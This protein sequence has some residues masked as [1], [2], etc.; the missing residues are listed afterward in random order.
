[1]AGNGSDVGHFDEYCGH[2]LVSDDSTRELM[3]CYWMLP[4]TS[5]I[6]AGD[7][8]T[9]TEFDIRSFDPLRL[10]LT[11]IDRAMMREDDRNGGVVLCY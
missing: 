11:E 5:V 4:S 10:L 2:L 9:A 7:L 1:M 3:G 8:Y 6:A